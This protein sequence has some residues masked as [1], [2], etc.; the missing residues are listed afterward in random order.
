MQTAVPPCCILASRHSRR[1]ICHAGVT[2]SGRSWLPGC[3]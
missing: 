1:K 3:G 2:R